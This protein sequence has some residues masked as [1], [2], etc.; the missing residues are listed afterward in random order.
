MKS[1]PVIEIKKLKPII[2]A[3]PILAR[4]PLIYDVNKSMH[5]IYK[6]HKDDMSEMVK[7]YQDS[8]K[9][10]EADLIYLNSISDYYAESIAPHENKFNEW[11]SRYNVVSFKLEIC[12]SKEVKDTVAKYFVAIFKQEPTE[13]INK[14][15][16]KAMRE[17]LLKPWWKASMAKYMKGFF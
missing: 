5:E 9:K 6:K 13:S 12:G 7:P 11:L 16:I 8:N 14:E 15:L 10:E 1:H 4:G 17:E 3:P 2:D